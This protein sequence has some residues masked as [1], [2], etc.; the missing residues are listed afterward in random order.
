MSHMPPPPPEPSA[1][2]PAAPIQIVQPPAAKPPLLRRVIQYIGTVV[3]VLSLVANLYMAM[4]IGAMAGH[5]FDTTTLRKG[6]EDKTVAVYT[7]G[8][9]INGESATGFG[10]FVR[11]IRDDDTIKAAVLRVDS[12]GGTVAASEQIHYMV[13]QL[14]ETGRPIVISMGSVAASGGYLIS[15]A[16]EDII[17]EPATITGSIGVIAQVPNVEGTMEKLGMKMYTY[18]STDASVWKDALNTFRPP[19]QHEITQLIDM[20]NIM[21]DQ[22]E[23]HVRTGRG[24]RLKVVEEQVTLSVGQG[25]AAHE[26]TVTVEAPLNGKAYLADEALKL[27]LIDQIGY[28][29]KAIDLAIERAGLD[30]PKVVE[31]QPREGLMSQIMGNAK[32]LSPLPEINLDTLATPRLMMIWKM[33]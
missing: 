7:I 21:Q 12:P 10:K 18:K 16:A 27:G 11:K 1:P 26:K 32:S 6:D 29:D 17:A 25:D 30:K 19:R 4:L 8:G 28:L 9:V 31:Y 13:T 24:D 23:Q 33:D 22:F 3:V 15:V 20:L 5:S 2:Q 14:K